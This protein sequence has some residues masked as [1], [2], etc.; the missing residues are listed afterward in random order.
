MDFKSDSGSLGHYL[1]QIF[2]NQPWLL[3]ESGETVRNLRAH[4]HC[5][6]T[7]I[8]VVSDLFCTFEVELAMCIDLGVQVYS[9]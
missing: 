1:Q 3:R 9:I 4:H 7:Y 6:S 5:L 8:D 2:Q